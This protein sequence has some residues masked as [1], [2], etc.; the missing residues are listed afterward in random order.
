MSNEE[1]QL[2]AKQLEADLLQ[3]FGSPILNLHQLQRALNYP[4]VIAVKQA[5]SRKTIAVRVFELPNRRG[6][7][8][9]AKDVAHFLAEQ[10]FSTKE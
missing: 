3:L 1:K 6:R 5:I 4:T 2:L 9:L 8:A 7:F 10:A